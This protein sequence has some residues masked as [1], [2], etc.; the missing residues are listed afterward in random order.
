MMTATTPRFRARERARCTACVR[1]VDP[2]MECAAPSFRRAVPEGDFHVR[3]DRSNRTPIDSG[4][5]AAASCEVSV[6]RTA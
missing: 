3:C 5:L 2:P 4:I 1:T 6:L